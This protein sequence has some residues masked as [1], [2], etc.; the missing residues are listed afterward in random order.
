MEG[1]KAELE[2]KLQM[3]GGGGGMEN[4]FKCIKHLLCTRHFTQILPSYSQHPLRGRDYRSHSQMRK[5]K[6]REVKQA[7]PGPHSNSL[8]GQTRTLP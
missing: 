6:P 5:M 1:S 2:A 7:A 3:R 8:N 4:V